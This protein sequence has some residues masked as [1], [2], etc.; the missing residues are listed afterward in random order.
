MSFDNPLFLLLL[1]AGMAVVRLPSPAS[2]WGLLALCVVFYSFA[3]AFDF[4]VF[5]S[6]I[7][8]NWLAGQ[9]VARSKLAFALAIIGNVAIL[10]FFKYREMLLPDALTSNYARIAIPLGISFY[11][12]HI[13]AYLA[14]VRMQ[15]VRPVGLH[16]FA[17]F[18]GFFPHLI[19]GP[20]VRVRQLMPQLDPL[21]AG[22]PPRRKLA[23]FGLAL[24][25]L[26]LVKKIV[27]SN[28]LAP[29]VD[30][31][32]R[33]VP[34]DSL[35]A[36]GGAWLFG[37][38]IYFDF[39]GYTDIALGATMLLG[40]RLPTNFL[41]PYM[42]ADPRAFWHRWH[43]TL[44]QWIRDY[45]YVPLGGSR[46]GGHLWQAF[47]L[48]GVMA[49]AGLWH[50][51]NWTF[52]A[53]GTFWG[54]YLL[55]W[56]WTAGAFLHVPRV[57]QWALHMAIVM[58][59]WVFFRAPDIGFAFRYIGRM[60]SFDAPV[61]STGTVMAVVG[62]AGLM[63][64]HWLESHLQNRRA[65]LWARRLSNPVAVGAMIGLFLLL[66]LFP[67]YDVNPFIYFRF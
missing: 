21:W 32:F 64:L 57:A 38:Q 26:G 29:V 11:L 12:F 5:A 9:Y 35:T 23:V 62:C 27:F 65:L 15:R 28:S 7:V 45:L 54:V 31:I 10:G 48:V 53:W 39:S 61:W 1:I 37:F 67:S 4:A 50:G 19:A 8:V 40:L 43:I 42:A 6:L 14:D 47:V 24:C 18:V 60:F 41:T 36:W 13:L 17:L 63:L 25:L 30:D 55:V 20:I 3:G 33:T 58:I 56:R 52:V 49:L 16:R 51:A 44:S 66:I 2:G 59:F 46:N 22:G 34:A